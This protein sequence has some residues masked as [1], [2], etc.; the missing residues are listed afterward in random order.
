[1]SGEGAAIIPIPFLPEENRR[2]G[3]EGLTVNGRQLVW[4]MRYRY[5]L[6][7]EK[8]FQRTKPS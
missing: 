7:A 8:A 2:H 1:M 5:M 3:A 6:A 4:R